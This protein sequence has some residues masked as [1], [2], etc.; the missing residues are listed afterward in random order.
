M[1]K[2]LKI[3]GG[4]LKYL[5]VYILIQLLCGI[6]LGISTLSNNYGD[7]SIYEIQL[8]VAKKI[9]YSLTFSS[10][11]TLLA[12]IFMFRKKET[13]LW[14]RCN[15]SIKV[16]GKNYIL[17][18][19]LAVTFALFT[20]SAIT[21][22]K[23]SIP[24]LSSV[25]EEFANDIATGISM[26][27]SPSIFTMIAIFLTVLIL[28]PVLEEVL[29]RGLIF[30]EL[31]NNDANIIASVII[32]AALFSIAHFNISQSS[33]TLILGVFLAL[34]YLWTKSLKSAIALHIGFNI[35]GMLIS[36]FVVAFA[37]KY[38]IFIAI[39]SFIMVCI[40]LMMLYKNRIKEET[41]SVLNVENF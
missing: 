38:T 26:G 31:K 1:G 15:M 2:F 36:P 6:V 41:N 40:S 22:F 24:S 12:Y 37:E 14:Q 25:P 28:G 39:L 30:N 32:Q 35:S 17:I 20:S 13:S 16:K 27:Y 29:F 18:M 11:I 33:Y 34:V 7:A 3:T 23:D 5:L 9:I 8:S 4:I 19:I 21:L 10:I